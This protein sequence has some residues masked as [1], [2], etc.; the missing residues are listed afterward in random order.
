MT[1]REKFAD[2][3]F[4]VSKYKDN[5]MVPF[6]N[7]M[8]KMK[9][10]NNDEEFETCISCEKLTT[11]KKTTNV[12]YRSGYIEGAGQLC[13]ECTER[14]DKEAKHAQKLWRQ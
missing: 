11:V 12:V 6:H 13:L 3:R 5:H 1:I 9:N 7:E 14:D 10:N 4:L 8:D 2:L